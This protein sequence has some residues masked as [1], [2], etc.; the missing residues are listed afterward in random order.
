M[1]LKGS[2][3]GTEEEEDGHLG[4]RTGISVN[5]AVNE[6]NNDVDKTTAEAANGL[7]WTSEG[8]KSLKKSRF[9][10]IPVFCSPV[11]K[12]AVM[13]L[14][15]VCTHHRMARE[16]ENSGSSRSKQA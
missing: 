11:Q 6:M 5:Q 7:W 15:T 16:E 1:R 4:E 9:L 3:V 8:S 10:E 13:C 2:G 12:M 14:Q